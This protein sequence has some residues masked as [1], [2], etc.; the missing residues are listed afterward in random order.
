MFNDR[1]KGLEKKIDLDSQKSF[2]L[3]SIRNKNLGKWAAEKLGL[4]A[5]MTNAYIDEVIS[6]DFDEPGHEDVVKKIFH[7]FQKKNI[8]LSYEE[9]KEKLLDFEREA[10]K[11]ISEQI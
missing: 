2:K 6:S 5:S 10:V 11:K 9:V 1:K 4:D 7:D 8:D 3:A